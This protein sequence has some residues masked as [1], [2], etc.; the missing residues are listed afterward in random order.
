[1]PLGLFGGGFCIGVVFGLYQEQIVLSFDD[2]KFA[3]RFYSMAVIMVGIFI[4]IYTIIDIFANPYIYLAY[5]LS[6]FIIIKEFINLNADP[7]LRILFFLL[8]LLMIVTTTLIGKSEHTIPPQKTFNIRMYFRKKENLP[9]HALAFFWGFFYT[10]T[11]YSSILLLEQEGLKVNLN[12]FVIVFFLTFIIA[13]FPTGFMMDTIGRKLTIL[14]GFSIQAF[15]FLILSFFATTDTLLLYII[16][17]ILGI[18]FS[19]GITGS[20]LIFIELPAREYI[21]DTGYFY[22]ILG[23]IGMINGMIIGEV[24]KPLLYNPIYLTV[25]LLFIFVIATFTVSQ[26]R[27][28]LPSKEELE[29]KSSVQYIYVLLKS[30]IP[31]YNQ[32]LCELQEGNPPTDECLFGGALV[33]VSSLLQEFTREKKPLKVIKQEG[34]SILLEEGENILVAIITIKELKI[35]RQKLQEFLEE[36]QDF[37]GELISKGIA[38]TTVFL[39][40]K[41]LAEK[42]FS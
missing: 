14:L 26:L 38:D 13:S 25:I 10:N 7:L 39:P 2:P 11:Y 5:S 15:A 41:K 21:R 6:P 1:M 27:E 23:G 24:I 40:A 34:F 4:I 19:M 28:T 8:I 42:H 35:I 9:E 16:P 30:G 37:F 18:G 3:G 29:W 36:F 32:N 31:I 33:A 12:I 20:F 22:I 17:I